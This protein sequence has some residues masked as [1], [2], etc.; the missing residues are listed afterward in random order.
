M[1][2]VGNDYGQWFGLITKVTPDAMLPIL[3]SLVAL[4]LITTSPATPFTV[5]YRMFSADTV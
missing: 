1:F 4:A 5:N 3:D 2:R